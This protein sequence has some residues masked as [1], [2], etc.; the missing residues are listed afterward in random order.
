MRAEIAECT[1]NEI[2]ICEG[3]KYLGEKVIREV[4]E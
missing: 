4:P 2:K 1:R 3:Y